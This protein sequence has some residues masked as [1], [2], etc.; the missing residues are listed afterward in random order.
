MLWSRFLSHFR[1]LCSIFSSGTL[2]P[3][4]ASVSPGP[5]RC[6]PAPE[7]LASWLIQANL[8]LQPSARSA[9]HLGRSPLCSQWLPVRSPLTSEPSLTPSSER[10][11]P[12]QTTGLDEGHFPA[13]PHV[14][15]IERGICWL[16][17]SLPETEPHPWD[18]PSSCALGHPS[19]QGSRVWPRAGPSPGFSIEWLSCVC[20]PGPKATG[21]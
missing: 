8:C 20:R 13:L 14:E 7:A 11:Q 12:P 19:T 16:R 5:Y 4:C 9:F 18:G 15:W 21:S 3:R 2:S 17:S 6:L 10:R 1:S